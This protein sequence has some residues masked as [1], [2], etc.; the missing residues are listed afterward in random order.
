MSTTPVDTIVC[1]E[2]TKVIGAYLAE[3]LLQDGI[4]VINSGGEIHV[5][6]PMSNI[7]G[8]LVFYDSEIEWIANKNILLLVATV[9][10]SNTV[11][12]AKECL[13][14]YNGKLVGISALFSASSDQTKQEINALFTSADIPG[15]KIFPTGEC[16]MCKTGHKLDAIVSS[17]GY[18]KIGEAT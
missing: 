17:E 10:S 9:S 18:T 2:N 3:E 15:Y 11:K 16:A 7:S 4:S 14:Y 12:S 13:S 5:V 6:T 8:K 1:L